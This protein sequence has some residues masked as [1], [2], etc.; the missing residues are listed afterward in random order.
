MCLVVPHLRYLVA[1]PRVGTEDED[2]AI[3]AILV[4]NAYLDNFIQPQPSF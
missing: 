4:P 2:A 1:T 3:F